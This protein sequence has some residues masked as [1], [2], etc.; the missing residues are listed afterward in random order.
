MY[1][2]LLWH[3]SRITNYVGILSEGL[4]VAPPDAPITGFVLGK[5][6]YFADIPSK[7]AHYCYANPEDN[8]GL[9]LLCE[10]A[11]GNIHRAV[12]PK[13]FKGPPIYHHSVR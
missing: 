3:G 2:A 10:V 5:G 6:I 13:P 9:L 4:R 11:L 1:K 12:K 8:E 7:A